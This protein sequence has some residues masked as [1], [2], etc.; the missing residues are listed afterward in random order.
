MSR[1]AAIAASALLQRLE[2]P[3]DGAGLA[4]PI[5]ELHDRPLLLLMGCPQFGGVADPIEMAHYPPAPAQPLTQPLQGIHH[6]RP[7]EGSARGLGLLALALLWSSPGTRQVPAVAIALSYSG[8]ALAA[9][10][11]ARRPPRARCR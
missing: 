9:R 2:G 1:F 3:V 4:G 8:F 10:W 5:A 7:A 6:L 11:W